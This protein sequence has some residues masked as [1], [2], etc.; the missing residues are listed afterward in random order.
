MSLRFMD[1]GLFHVSAPF[2]RQ[3]CLTFLPLIFTI[4]TASIT[5]E[6]Q[7][8]RMVQFC[9]TSHPEHGAARLTSRPARVPIRVHPCSSVVEGPRKINFAFFGAGVLAAGKA[10]ARNISPICDERTIPT[11]REQENQSDPMSFSFPAPNLV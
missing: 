6:F 8:S 4:I 3:M 9:S 7:P 11:R 10:R 1:F 2:L 5:C